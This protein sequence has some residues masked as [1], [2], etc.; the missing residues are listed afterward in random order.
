MSYSM[1]HAYFEREDTD[2]AVTVAQLYEKMERHNSELSRPPTE[3]LD[4]RAILSQLKVDSPCS[5]F[6][7][8]ENEAVDKLLQTDHSENV[9]AFVNIMWFQSFVALNNVSKTLMKLISVSRGDFTRA[10]AK[11]HGLLTSDEF[12]H[13]SLC[14]F[15]V[16]CCTPAQ[17]SIGVQLAK[18]IYLRFLQHLQIVTTQ[19]RQIQAVVFN[20]KEMSATGRAK[21]RHVG[22][23][24]VRKV[25]EQSRRYVRMNIDSENTEM[26]AGVKR[27]HEVCELNE[28][29][30]IGS[31]AVLE[32]ASLHKDTLQVSEARQYRE[33]GLIHIKDYVY[34]FFT[35]FE[36]E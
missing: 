25:L 18:A 36:S 4:T 34:T 15:S 29:S 12:L 16:S 27:H 3:G 26:M 13:Y 17:R 35:A 7:R 8:S 28:E 11:L 32:Q 24:A 9:E 31:L 5:D 19:D 30:F 22:G 33:R 20:V 2:V 14:L 6:S 21:V 1:V 10:T 23:W